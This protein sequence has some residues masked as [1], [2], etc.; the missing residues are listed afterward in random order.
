M[1]KWF[2]KKKQ[3]RKIKLIKEYLTIINI[4]NLLIKKIEN[5][6]INFTEITF[7]LKDTNLFFYN[8]NQ[9]NLENNEKK[10]SFQT[11]EEAIN[12][13][14]ESQAKYEE[15]IKK[16][17]NKNNKKYQNLIPLN[18]EIEINQSEELSLAKMIKNP[19]TLKNKNNDLI[20]I[21]LNDPIDN[22]IDANLLIAK[23][24][25]DSNNDLQ[26]SNEQ[27]KTTTLSSYV[28]HD[29][30]PSLSQQHLS[31]SSTENLINEDTDHLTKKDLTSKIKKYNIF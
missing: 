30:T 14:E 31:F 25:T 8:L 29:S 26:S 28:Y 15:K 10:Y 7:Y 17:S 2:Q 6:K 23:S 13:L 3:K 27:A 4:I 16:I 9:Y 20:K 21:N 1:F 12:F 22:N 5:I 19:I 11:K 24:E 18:E